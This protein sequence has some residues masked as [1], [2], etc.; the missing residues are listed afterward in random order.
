MGEIITGNHRIVRY[1]RK[2]DDHFTKKTGTIV[3]AGD[4]GFSGGFNDWLYRL[5]DEMDPS[6]KSG[7]FTRLPHAP[8]TEK[9]TG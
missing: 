8:D 3:K 7:D 2:T 4:I 5:L 1:A 9:V 6:G